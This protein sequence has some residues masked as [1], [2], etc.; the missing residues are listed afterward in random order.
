MR[1][2]LQEGSDKD[3]SI[4]VGRG[5]GTVMASR[6]KNGN[7]SHHITRRKGGTATHERETKEDTVDGRRKEEERAEGSK[8]AKRT[9]REEEKSRGESCW[10]RRTLRG[11]WEDGPFKVFVVGEVMWGGRGHIITSAQEQP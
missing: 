1:R 10:E 9:W 4:R 6:G 8:G 3:A 2:A 11:S 5:K 7:K